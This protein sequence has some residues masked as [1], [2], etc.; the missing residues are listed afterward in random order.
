MKSN[1]GDTLVEVL[2]SI[3][4][5]AIIFISSGQMILSIK[6]TQRNIEKTTNMFLELEKILEIFTIEPQTFNERLEI[7]YPVVQA[8]HFLYLY[9]DSQFNISKKVTDNYFIIDVKEITS[10]D[11]ITR[12]FA[13]EVRIYVNHE[14]YPLDQKCLERTICVE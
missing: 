6:K 12:Y 3:V 2:V 1:K 13:I 8:N 14:E 9:Y 4:V 7:I 11:Q 5:L 10:D